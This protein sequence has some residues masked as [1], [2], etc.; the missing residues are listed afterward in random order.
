MDGACGRHGGKAKYINTG[1]CGENSS[2]E[3]IWK[4]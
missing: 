3:T 2:E 1:F 4:T